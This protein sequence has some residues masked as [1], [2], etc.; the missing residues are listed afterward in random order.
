[1]AISTANPNNYFTEK[2]MKKTAHVHAL[3]AFKSKKKKTLKDGNREGKEK[4]GREGKGKKRKEMKGN[5][6]K[7]DGNTSYNLRVWEA[8]AE[9]L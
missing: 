3:S 8:K 4:W 7:S 6:R 2:E 9:L 5:E 1:M